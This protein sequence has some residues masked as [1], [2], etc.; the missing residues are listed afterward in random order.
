[1]TGL[2]KTQIEIIKKIFQTF[3]GYVL[4]FGSRVRG[5]FRPDSDLDICLKRSVGKISLLELGNLREALF[6]SPLPF[7]VDLFDYAD[8]NPVFR[9]K[10]EA[11]AIDLN[12]L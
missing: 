12:R 3:D 5:S 6:Q 7:I 4:I 2:S 11:E 1:M 8:A 9:A 10:I